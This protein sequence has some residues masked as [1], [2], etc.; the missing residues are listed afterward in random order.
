M[1]TYLDFETKIEKIQEEIVSAHAIAN[2]D[3]VEKLQKDL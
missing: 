1:A 2:M 3:A